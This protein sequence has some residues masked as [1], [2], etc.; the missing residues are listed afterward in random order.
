[1]G[2]GQVWALG[3]CAW[4]RACMRAR[5]C[6]RACAGVTWNNTCTAMSHVPEAPAEAVATFLQHYSR[7][8]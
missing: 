3:R 8:D 5:A 2:V 7:R 6:T 4:L 1:M